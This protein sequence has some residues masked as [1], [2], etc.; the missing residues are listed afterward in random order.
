LYT[1]SPLNLG[2]LFNEAGYQIE[3]S[4]PYFHK[5]PPFY[6]V[7]AKLG[8]APFNA[9]CLVYGFMRKST[10]QVIVKASKE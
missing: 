6:K 9:I 7:F 1:W 5:W 3:F 8:W 4:K 2:N 10:A